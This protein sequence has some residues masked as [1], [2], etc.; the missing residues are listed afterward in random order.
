MTQGRSL[1]AQVLYLW[2]LVKRFRLTFFMLFVLVFG[3]GTALFFLHARAGRPIGFSRAVAA[4]YFLL[5]AQ[6]I[7]DIPDVGPSRRWR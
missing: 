6:P 5:F 2:T 7:I 4:A 3:G 1:Q